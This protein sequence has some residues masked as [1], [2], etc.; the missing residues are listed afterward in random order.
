[1]AT[2]DAPS[3]VLPLGGTRGNMIVLRQIYQQQTT[4][5]KKSP[6]F[7]K[8][9][10]FSGILQ[11]G[12]A[13][14]TMTS[15]ANGSSSRRGCPSSSNLLYSDYMKPAIRLQC[16]SGITSKIML[17]HDSFRVVRRTYAPTYRAGSTNA[18]VGKIKPF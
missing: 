16:D 10:D 18:F 14:L 17:T 13:E 6:G 11:A 3:A 7:T 5:S 2:R 8:K 4:V 9:N 1:M 15:I 12:V